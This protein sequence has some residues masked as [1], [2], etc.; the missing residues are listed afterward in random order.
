MLELLTSGCMDQRMAPWTFAD[1]LKFPIL[2][3]LPKQFLDKRP[4]DTKDFGDF[5]LRPRA[6]LVR[7]NNLLPQIQRIRSG[8]HCTITNSTNPLD[9]V[10]AQRLRSL[11]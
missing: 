2:P 6:T 5:C 7:T 8:H 4:A 3:I 9:G 11:R 1:R 10:R